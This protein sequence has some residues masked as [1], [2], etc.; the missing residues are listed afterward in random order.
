MPSAYVEQA[1]ASRRRVAR[2]P[3]TSPPHDPDHDIRVCQAVR[4]AVGDEFRMHYQ[5]RHGHMTTRRRCGS[6]SNKRR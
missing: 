2:L 3:N 1:L 5:L 4:K 6:R